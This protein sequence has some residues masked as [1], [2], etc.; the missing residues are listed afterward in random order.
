[1]NPLKDWKVKLERAQS[2]KVR[3]DRITVCVV[4]MLAF[5]GSLVKYI[6]GTNNFFNRV[7]TS[8]TKSSITLV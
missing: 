4:I 6:P 1:M 7:S 8:K 3:S 5:Y 2:F